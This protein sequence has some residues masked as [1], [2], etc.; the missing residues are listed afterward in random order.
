MYHIYHVVEFSVHFDGRSLVC[1]C[2]MM[3]VIMLKRE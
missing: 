2:M 3:I 1:V